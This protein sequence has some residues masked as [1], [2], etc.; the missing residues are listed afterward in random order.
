MTY[1]VYIVDDRDC[2]G[3]YVGSLVFF[4]GEHEFT[5]YPDQ[6]TVCPECGAL[7]L[8]NGGIKRDHDYRQDK[9]YPV[10]R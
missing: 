10:G 9:E 4:C 1:N 3:N 8:W 7:C 6:D 2:N 5:G